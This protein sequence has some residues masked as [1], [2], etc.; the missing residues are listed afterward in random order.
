MEDIGGS[1]LPFY[2]NIRNDCCSLEAKLLLPLK[3]L[4]YGVDTNTFRDY[5]RM[6][7][8]QAG[9]ACDE[10]DKVIVYM[11]K[12]KYLQQPTA[13]DLRQLFDVHQQ[14]HKFPGMLGS[15]G[16]VQEPF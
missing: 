1:G 11:Y 2:S 5:F 6:S 10:F 16:G 13:H 14:K 3:T 7:K 12:G 4:A 9:D 15:L 8:S